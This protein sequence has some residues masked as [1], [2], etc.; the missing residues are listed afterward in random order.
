MRADWVVRGDFIPLVNKE[1]EMVDMMYVDQI[2]WLR[3][4]I[5]FSGFRLWTDEPMALSPVPFDYD[6]DVVNRVQA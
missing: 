2:K 1:G 4:S 5:A 3:F 6:L